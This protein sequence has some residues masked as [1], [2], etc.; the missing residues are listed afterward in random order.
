MLNETLRDKRIIRESGNKNLNKV[1][2]LE[3]SKRGLSLFSL[4][5]KCDLCYFTSLR[6]LIFQGC[7]NVN[8]NFSTTDNKGSQKN[9]LCFQLFLGFCNNKRTNFPRGTNLITIKK[10]KLK[11]S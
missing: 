2:L 9:R 7:I 3:S 1:I 11:A 5:P 10:T 4:C 6:H 8:V